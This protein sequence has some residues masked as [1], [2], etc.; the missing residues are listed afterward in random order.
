MIPAEIRM[1]IEHGQ[2]SA[3]EE[4]TWKAETKTE[5]FVL[6]SLKSICMNAEVDW[7]QVAEGRPFVL[8]M[9][10]NLLVLTP[11][12]VVSS[13]DNQTLLVHT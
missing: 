12:F 10:L 7:T 11:A 5:G 4:A 13:D 6:N 8:L 3:R 9:V 2:K 1:S